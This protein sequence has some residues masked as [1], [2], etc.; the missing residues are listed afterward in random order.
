LRERFAE[1]QGA[2]SANWRVTLE[3]QAGG[4]YVLAMVLPLV[5][6]PRIQQGTWAREGDRLVLR[7]DVPAEDA[8]DRPIT[9]S[10]DGDTVLLQQDELSPRFELRRVSR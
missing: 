5:P 8:A 7:P 9:A 4:R 1:L 6:T 10:W 2:Q 3:V